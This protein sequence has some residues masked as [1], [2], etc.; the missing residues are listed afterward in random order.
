MYCF[1]ALVQVVAIDT[2]IEVGT[3]YGRKLLRGPLPKHMVEKIWDY[4]AMPTRSWGRM[5]PLT[6]C[7]NHICT[8]HAPVPVIQV[9]VDVAEIH[10]HSRRSWFDHDKDLVWAA[11]HGALRLK[12]KINFETSLRLDIML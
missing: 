11:T 6:D 2:T 5:L 9:V 7:L 4:S 12:A 1:D 8:Q 3:L 10:M